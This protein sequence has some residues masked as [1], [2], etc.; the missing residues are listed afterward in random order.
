M[1]PNSDTATVHRTTLK[2]K[3]QNKQDSQHVQWDTMALN[4]LCYLESKVTT[5]VIA[6]VFKHE[7]TLNNFILFCVF[8]QFSFS[9]VDISSLILGYFCTQ[10]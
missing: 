7:C 4:E 2:V 9:I 6:T 10:I 3:Q 5:C 1:L 8:I